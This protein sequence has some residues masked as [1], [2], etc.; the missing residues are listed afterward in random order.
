M[1]KIGYFAFCLFALSLWSCEMFRLDNYDAPSETLRGTV[2]DV[3]TGEPVLTDQGS[4]GIRVRL[5]ETSY[6]DNVEH[7][8]DFYCMSDGTFQ[9]TKLFKGTYNVRIDGPFIPLVR[10][11]PNGVPLANETQNVTLNGKAVDMVFEVQPFLKVVWDGEPTASNGKISAK[12]K[13]TRGVSTEE[14]KTKIQPTMGNSYSD[15]YQNVSEVMLMVSYSSSVGYRARDDRWSTSVKYSGKTFEPLLGTS[16]SIRSI[17][18]IPSGRT[19][20]VRAA[21]RINYATP[22]GS[23]TYRWNYSE[24]IMI[25]VP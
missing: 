18:E 3:A 25:I 16:V 5:T 2:V 20:F 1:K 9:N 21:A 24:P 17:G 12:L 14:F 6:G 4:E 11:D 23:G 10:E 13:V 22:A 8:P 15:A 7:N 19:V